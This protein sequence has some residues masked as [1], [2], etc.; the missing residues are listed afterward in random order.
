[1]K[2]QHGT[3]PAYWHDKC[4]CDPCRENWIRYEKRRRYLADTGRPLTVEALGFK[5]RVQALMAMGWQH[6]E[7]ATCLG[8][9]PGN[10]SHR[11]AYSARVRQETHARMVDVYAQ[12][13][14]RLPKDTWQSRR[15]R[16]LAQGRGW[17]SPL[18]W[19]DRDLDDPNARPHGHVPTD[20]TAID[21]VVVQRLLNQQR[22]PSTPAE[23]DEAMRRWV[24]NGG[25]RRQLAL[26]HGWN[27]GR[28]GKDQE[29]AS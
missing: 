9:K 13:S 23:K 24:A 21:E 1:M 11:M 14:G 29:A 2:Y 28:H 27:D 22:T 5:R 3:N 8:I 16:S 17:P 6:A 4:R 7:I 10:L 19:N 26:I 15:T 18:A 25:S 12:L 20:R